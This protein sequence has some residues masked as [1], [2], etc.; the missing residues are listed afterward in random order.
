MGDIIAN[1]IEFAIKNTVL[2]FLKWLGLGLINSSYWICLIACLIA[3]LLYISGQRKAG[4]YVSLSFI[5]YVLL[6]SIKGAFL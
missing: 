2:K 5:I 6:Q 1:S 4:K 3:L